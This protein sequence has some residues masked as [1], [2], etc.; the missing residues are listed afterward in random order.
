M[1]K[2]LG[3]VLN[4][5]FPQKCI[6]CG[7]KNVIL[8]E[9]CMRSFPFGQLD[10]QDNIFAA[11]NYN[12]P[13][14]QKAIWLLKYRNIKSMAEPLADLIY[15]RLLNKAELFKETGLLNNQSPVSK[16]DWLIVPVP[17]SKAR[18]QERGFN[19]SELIAKHL[20]NKSGIKLETNVL[21]KF[22]NTPSQVDIK[23]RS[24][25]LGNIVGSFETKNNHLIKDKNIILIDDV[26]TTGATL[27]ECKKVLRPAGAKK[28]I[29]FTVARG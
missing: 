24:E 25:R 23:N 26:T 5:L 3:T 1:K 9:E 28:I 21:Y 8:C 4:F 15:K 14:V 7:T 18:L 13:V 29:S 6:G 2:I 11:T 17:I 19:Q 20:A 22:K 16:S 12:Y 27:S 10:E